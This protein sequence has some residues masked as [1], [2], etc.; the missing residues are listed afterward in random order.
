MK[1]EAGC[2]SELF[3]TRFASDARVQALPNFLGHHEVG[4]GAASGF[5]LFLIGQ[6]FFLALF[7][8]ATPVRTVL[9]KTELVR[10]QVMLVVVRRQAF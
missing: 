2:R 5:A 3:G 7:A 9:H 10:L 4:L 1:I 8:L 6:K